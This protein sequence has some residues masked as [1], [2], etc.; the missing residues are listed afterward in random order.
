MTT[1]LIIEDEPISLGLMRRALEKADLT[2]LCATSM[3]DAQRKLA[4][5]ADVSAIILDRQLPDGDGL[6]FFQTLK[7]TPS[8]CHIPVIIN[9]ALKNEND[10]RQGIDAGAYWYLTKPIKPDLL[11]SLVRNAVE[12]FEAEQ[13]ARDLSKRTLES[14]HFIKHA[15][16]EFKTIEQAE[17]V[18]ESVAELCPEPGRALLGLTEIL[19][20][21]VEHGNLAIT[22][23]EKTQLM[24]EDNY[25]QEIA[26]RQTLDQYKQ[27]VVS[28]RV[29]VELT[30]TTIVVTDEGAGFDWEK[31][32]TFDP[33]RL[34]D[35]HGRGIAMTKQVSFDE[36][37]YLGKGNVVELV[38]L[39]PNCV[40]NKHQ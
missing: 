39:T 29:D 9:S 36:L 19:K 37:N 38:M 4:E 18:A 10:I 12:Q 31:Y 34:F 22:Y 40:S 23:E 16:Y 17:Q 21:A 3:F 30:R 15:V 14:L 2:A 8:T 27:K 13:K 24:V 32:L 26:R 25:D 7:Q 11:L 35:P 5:N 20:N 1:V 28:V 33:E 6:V